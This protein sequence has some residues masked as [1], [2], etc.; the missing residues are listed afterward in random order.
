[1]MRTPVSEH[2][3]RST[4]H[5]RLTFSLH[6]LFWTTTLVSL[7]SQSPESQAQTERQLPNQ[8][9]TNVTEEAGI[10]WAQFSGES[11]DRFL[12]ETMGGGVAFLDF[13][14]DGLLDIFLV[15]G[16]E[17][18]NGK[19]A[20]PIRNALYRNLGDGKFANVAARAGVDQIASYGM[21]AAVADFDNDGFPDLYVTGFPSSYLFHNNRDGTFTDITEQA[22]VKNAGRW[23]ASA[24]WFDFDRDGLLDL[25]VTNYAQFS[26]ADRKKCE[27]KGMPA[28]C[29]Q[30]SYL[31]M[32]LT[33]FHNDGSG[34]FTDV[35]ALSGVAKLVGRAL[36]VVA[37]DVDDD[38]WAD[39]FV[40]RDASPNLLLINQKDGTFRDIAVDA[41]VAYDAAGVAKAGMGV[42]AG[43]VNRDGKPDFVVTNFNDQ[44]HSLLE[45]TPALAYDD[46]TMQSGLARL[47]KKFVGWGVHYIDFDNDGNLDLLVVNGHIN[48]GIEATRVD[49]KYREP[50]LLLR[51]NGK[52][53]FEDMSDRAG[54]VFQK[55]YSA[56]GLAVG[57]WN[58]DGR[59]DAVYTTLNASPILLRNDSKTQN[60]WI[61]LELQGVKS[62]R[63]AIAA[64]ITVEVGRTKLVRWITGG[65]S[66][67]ASHDKRV[68]V[69]LGK[70]PPSSAVRVEIRW[71]NGNVQRPA[72]LKLD[73][74]NHVVEAP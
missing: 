33:L 18:P 12:I 43:D 32:P 69:G 52:G 9:F 3:L 57:D 68:V 8:I 25:I 72:G 39:L 67:L 19:S 35:S 7:S 49:V 59:V 38:G 26:F 58:N 63:D 50:A 17:T 70:L 42:D 61:G 11:P 20:S 56:R 4:S 51:N 2:L 5:Y 15:N 55:S 45:A 13:D 64:K 14:G 30:T 16:G 6:V 23:A 34:H 36:G 54:D 31:G 40:A 41:E 71:P 46:R 65:S 74:Y 60:S 10:A 24:A 1:M 44:Y 62:N 22:G 53:S 21:G 66:Y 73:R 48:Q 37:I 47:T 28:Y 27:I 29:A